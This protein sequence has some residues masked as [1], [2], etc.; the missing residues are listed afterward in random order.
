MRRKW[1]YI[2]SHFRQ[3]HLRHTAIYTRYGV[4]TL[5]LGREGRVTSSILASSSAK[6]A[7][8]WVSLS[9]TVAA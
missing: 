6:S 5:N 2:R 3:Q 4:E 9:I 7:S 8:C 1:I